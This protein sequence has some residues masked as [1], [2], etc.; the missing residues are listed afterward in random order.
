MFA[1]LESFN[2]DGNRKHF[3]VRKAQQQT[4]KYFGMF[5][6]KITEKDLENKSTQMKIADLVKE[7]KG[8]DTISDIESFCKFFKINV[9]IFN[10]DD[11][12][13][14][15][16]INRQTIVDITY[17]TMNILEVI[18]SDTTRSSKTVEYECI[19]RNKNNTCYEYY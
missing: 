19:E 16:Q 2:H 18:V 11:Q 9:I 13:N 7:Y 15:Y 5:V 12:R 3:D 1:A 4:R 10:Y 17:K 8:F 14:I 6:H